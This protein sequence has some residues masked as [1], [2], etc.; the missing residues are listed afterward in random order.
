M[1]LRDVD[2]YFR[3]HLEIDALAAV[4]ASLNGIQVGRRN[5][6]IENVAFGVD[7]CMDAF[8]RA[9]DGGADVLF[10]HHGLYFGRIKPVTGHYYERL[11]YLFDNDLALYAAHLP[12]D[13]HPQFGNNAGIASALGLVEVEPFGEYKGVTIGY[14]GRLPEAW[15]LQQIQAAIGS[16]PPLGVLPF[17]PEEVRT[18]GIV[19]GGAPYDVSQAIEQ[20]LDCYITG[21]ASHGIYHEALESKINVVFGGHYQTEVWGARLLAQRTAADTGL[22]TFFVDVPTGL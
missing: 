2:A 14:K 13:Q 1:L 12:L 5:Q 10:V 16:G 19:S 15:S 11:R 7:A 9:V 8:R 6:E 4:D 20:G 22:K 21:D 17:G 3:Q 18:V